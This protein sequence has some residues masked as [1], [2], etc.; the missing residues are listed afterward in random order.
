MPAGR[1]CLICSSAEKTRIAAEMIAAGAADQAIADR[2]G[3]GLHR[4]AVSRHRRAHVV[5]PA[6]ALAEMAGK[7][8]DAVEQRAQVLAAAEAGDPSAFV[9][10]AAIV[11]DLRKVHERLERT[12]DAAELDNQRLAVSSLSAQQLRA[13]EVRAKIG[14]V[15]GYAAHKAP[16][17]GDAP[18]FAV[19]IHLGDG[20]VERIEAIAGYPEHGRTIDH[21]AVQLLPA[22]EEPEPARLAMPQFLSTPMPE[23]WESGDP[24]EAGEE[25]ENE[26]T[27]RPGYAAA[28]AHA[29]RVDGVAK[30]APGPATG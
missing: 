19:N 4:M 30:K 12:A 24:E 17:I 11:N 20:R 6:K 26:S 5:A 7:G 22:G 1:P 9:A 18:M 23:V 10:L 8:R 16:G 2:L 13:A 25:P 21:E 29:F 14:G 3:D 15:G 28:A 27:Y